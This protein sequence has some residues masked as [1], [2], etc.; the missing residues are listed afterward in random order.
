MELKYLKNDSVK[1]FV[2]IIT[3]NLQTRVD[4]VDKIEDKLTLFI[5]GDDARE[6]EEEQEG[7]RGARRGPGAPGRISHVRH[8]IPHHTRGLG[9]GPSLRP[10][11]P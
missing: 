6:C 9:A 4:V 1:Q 10:V 5:F 8:T 2:S 11:Y 3:G 7:E